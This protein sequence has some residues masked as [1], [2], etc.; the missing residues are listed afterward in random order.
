M[1]KQRFIFCSLQSIAVGMAVVAG[2]AAWG[3]TN[4]APAAA[5]NG[6]NNAVSITDA[7]TELGTTT[8]LG[9]LKQTRTQILT[10]VGATIHDYS[11]QFKALGYGSYILS[12]WCDISLKHSRGND[13]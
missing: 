4:N 10:A 2:E 9:S 11:Q 8:V 3:Q 7:A 5:A 6:T 12:G 13:E 1:K